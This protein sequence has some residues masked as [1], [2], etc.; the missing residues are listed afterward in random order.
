M[1]PEQFCYWLQGRAELQP[2]VP[3]SDAEWK[4]VREHLAT[5]FVKVTPHLSLSEHIELPG[6]PMPGI[7][8]PLYPGLT[9]TVTC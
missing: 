1:T 3:L 5:V 7:T 2:D 6:L 4:S 8:N 9:T